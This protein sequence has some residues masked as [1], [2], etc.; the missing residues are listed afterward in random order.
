VP[1]LHVEAAQM[2]G[3][4]ARIAHAADVLVARM[5]QGSGSDFDA[6]VDSYAPVLK[7][8]LMA[9]ANVTAEWYHQLSPG[10][11]FPVGLPPLPPDEQLQANARWAIGETLPATN[12]DEDVFGS[13]SMDPADRLRG[14]TERHVYDA[15]RTTVVYNADRENVR[16]ARQARPDACAFCRLLAQRDNLYRTEKSATMVVGLR[17]KPRGGRPLGKQYHDN[18]HCVAVP[19]RPGTVY[20]PPEYVDDWVEQYKRAY[21]DPDTRTFKDIVNH[22]RRQEYAEARIAGPVG[23]AGL[24]QAESPFSGLSI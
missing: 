1:P 9:A 24:T 8:F 20:H 22:M 14:T 2:Q 15:S 23:E 16:Y 13:L 10:S 7:P 21:K 12:G 18:C 5:Y 17:G 19:V 6:L 3:V 4:L 11:G